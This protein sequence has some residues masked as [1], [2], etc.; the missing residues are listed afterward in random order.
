[1]S[2]T[3][4]TDYPIPGGDVIGRASARLSATLAHISSAASVEIDSVGEGNISLYLGD[5]SVD[6]PA[7]TWR[8]IVDALNAALAE[9][10]A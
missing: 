4:P 1:M 2:D 5:L 9:V 3:Q 6:M 8:P 7:T 10:G